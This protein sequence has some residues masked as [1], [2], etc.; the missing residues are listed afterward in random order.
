MNPFEQPN[1]YYPLLNL[2]PVT[3]SNKLIFQ[4]NNMFYHHKDRTTTHVNG[5]INPLNLNKNPEIIRVTPDFFEIVEKL[6]EKEEERTRTVETRKFARRRRKDSCYTSIETH[7]PKMTE[8][9]RY[10]LNKEQ[11]VKLLS[12]VFK[13]APDYEEE[14]HQTRIEMF[15]KNF[16]EWQDKTKQLHSY[17]DKIDKFDYE[18]KVLTN[19]FDR[20]PQKYLRLRIEV[21][22]PDEQYIPS[23][24]DIE[25]AIEKVDLN[26]ISQYFDI[27]EYPNLGAMLPEK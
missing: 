8:E 3:Q 18:I 19:A 14:S 6:K 12:D 2:N 4:I 25:S 17:Q 16:E 23:K 15:Y 1:K 13:K 21:P 20:H 24:R 11:F 9:D 26:D 27:R 5:T 10:L 7:Y 22:F